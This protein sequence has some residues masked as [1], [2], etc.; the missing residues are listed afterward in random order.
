MKNIQTHYL[1]ANGKYYGPWCINGGTL[2]YVGPLEHYLHETKHS[3][4]EIYITSPKLN[5]N[6]EF[7]YN[8]M[9]VMLRNYKLILISYDK[10][11]TWKC[12]ID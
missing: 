10:G 5:H 8:D 4:Y 6:N 7:Q 11:I 1:P 2:E 12:L 9:G 3:D